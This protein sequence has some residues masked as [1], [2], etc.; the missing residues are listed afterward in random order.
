MDREIA[1]ALIAAIA[2]MAIIGN[3]MLGPSDRAARL[4]QENHATYA[5]EDIRYKLQQA[6]A[7]KKRKAPAK[8]P[9]PEKFAPAGSTTSGGGDSDPSDEA[10][11]EPSLSGEPE[12][13]EPPL[14]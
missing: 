8:P 14:D 10:Q 11:E 1:Y 3:F 13:E 12:A 6:E 2:G 7:K 4:E 5:P 9:A